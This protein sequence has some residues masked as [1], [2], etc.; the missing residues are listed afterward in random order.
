[1]GLLFSGLRLQRAVSSRPGAGAQRVD[2]IAG[3][4]VR[5]RLEP[6]LLD[7]VGAGALGRVDEA[8]SELRFV[9]RMRRGIGQGGG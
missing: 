8:V 3:E 7:G 9:H 6:E 4:L 5:H 1:M 2:A